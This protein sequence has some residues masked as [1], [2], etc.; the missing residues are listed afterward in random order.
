MIEL[1]VAIREEATRRSAAFVLDHIPLHLGRAGEEV[2][3]WALLE[4]PKRGLF[5]ELGVGG[6]RSLRRAAKIRPD[7]THYG[8]DS[9]EGLP[10]P[11][12]M[13]PIGEFKCEPPDDLPDNVQVITGW[14]D[15]SL[16]KFLRTHRATLAF[17]HVDCDL[18]SSTMTA[19]ALL[20]P[21]MRAGTQIVLD[22]FYG[23]P[24]FERAE[25][26]AWL[27]FAR[28]FAVDFE[29]TG[30]AYGQNATQVSVEVTNA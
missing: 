9:F 13:K 16:P 22:D 19:L 29:Y 2:H 4:A 20:R 10:E 12:S 30:Y 26:K 21:R 11:W 24:G 23:E 15:E 5:L 17:A 1:H 14:F 8:F 3:T 27:D 6:G 25:Q 7:V 28:G 18:Y